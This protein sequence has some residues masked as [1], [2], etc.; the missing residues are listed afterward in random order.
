[1]YIFQCSVNPKRNKE[2]QK[3]TYHNVHLDVPNHCAKYN[4]I[5]IGS[6]LKVPLVTLTLTLTLTLAYRANP[7]LSKR[8]VRAKLKQYPPTTTTTTTITT[9]NNVNNSPNPATE[10]NTNDSVN[11]DIK[12]LANL[13]HP[14]TPTTNTFG[15]QGNVTRCNNHNCPL[16]SRLI[17]STQVRSNISRRTFHT[18][19]QATCDT[20]RVVYMIQCK[21]CGKQYVGQT[22]QPLKTRIS[23]HL[24]AIKNKHHPGALQEHFRKN[25]CTGINNVAV[26]LLQVITPG[27]H[28]TTE[29]VENVL[30]Q[31]ESLWMDRLKCEYPQGLNWAKYDPAKRYKK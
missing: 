28:D 9:G 22:A 24:Q 8:L 23:K 12:R 6:P 19:G 1:M 7:N 5:L 21:K 14:A 10:R 30:K 2:I 29:K 20:P 25:R 3:S 15:R 17:D 26:Q 4:G 16:H 11:L 18:H 13:K 27:D 31:H